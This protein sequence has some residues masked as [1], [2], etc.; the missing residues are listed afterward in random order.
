MRA[1]SCFEGGLIGFSNFRGG[2]FNKIVIL[3]FI[4]LTAILTPLLL[5]N[6]ADME[7]NAVIVFSLILIIATFIDTNI[8]LVAILLS[9]LLSPELEAGASAGRAVVIRAEDLLLIIV[10]LTWL[11]KMALKKELPFVRHSPLNAPIGMYIAVLFISTLKGISFGDVSPEKGLFFVF[12]IIEY[13]VLYFIIL[14]HTVDL[15]QVK[16]FLFTLI[17][18]SFVVGIYCNTHLG[19]AARMSAPFEGQGEPNTLGAYLLFILCIIAGVTFYEKKFRNWLI[20]LFC[21]LLPPFIFTLSRASYLGMLP[22]LATFSF[23]S[24]RLKVLLFSVVML[25]GFI[26]FV[27]VG[28]PALKQRDVG[29][30]QPETNQAVQKIGPISLGPSPAARIESWTYLLK[31]KFPKRPILGY[32]VTG[33]SFLD[34]Q[35]LTVLGETGIIGLCIFLWLFWRIW[36]ISLRNFRKVE[37]PLLK[38]LILGYLAGFIGLLFHALG[39]N[40]FII[41]RIAEPFWFLTAIVVKLPD[42]ETGK[43]QMEDRIPRY[44]R[45]RVRD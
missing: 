25:G 32:G 18:T 36:V 43:A 16:L 45:Y 40:T 2:N 37:T 12:K 26:C 28:P 19:S 5:T 8:G 38:G 21:F 27:L 10:S 11:A 44:A 34:G 31:K 9:M 7:S 39:S 17:I 14:N 20:S 41:I 35:Y 29:A 3:F 13:F 15:K 22:A 30:F 33:I 4:V 42:I 1:F 23:L 24:K 6:I